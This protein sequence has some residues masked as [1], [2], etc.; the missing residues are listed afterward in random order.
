MREAPRTVRAWS[1][2]TAVTW[3][4]GLGGWLSLWRTPIWSTDDLVFAIRAGHPGGA[5][6]GAELWHF[7]QVDVWERNGRTADAWGQAIFST[8]WAIGPLMALLCLAQSFLWWRLLWVCLRPAIPAR[9]AP[10]AAWGCAVA[11]LAAPFALHHLVARLAGTVFFFMSATVGYLGGMVLLGGSLLSALQL[12]RRATTARSWG[13][14]AVVLLLSGA[15]GA[16]HN[17]VIALQLIA[18][19][20]LLSS[21]LWRRRAAWGPRATVWV[22]LALSA[23]RFAAPGLWARTRKVKAPLPLEE[24]GFLTRRA[25]LAAMSLLSQLETAGR[26]YLGIALAVVA[27]G[28]WVGWHW[29]R[30]RALVGA[31]V[32]GLGGGGALAGWLVPRLVAARTAANWERSALADLF[33]SRS[34]LLLVLALL[35]AGGCAVALAGLAAWQL[36]SLEVGVVLTAAVAAYAVPV[37]L[38]TTGPRPFYFGIAL[39]YLLALALAGLT[40]AAPARGRLTAPDG[41]PRIAAAAPAWR[42]RG[43]RVVSGAAAAASLALLLGPAG[44]GAGQL[45]RDWGG[46]MAAWRQVEDQLRAAQAGQVTEVVIPRQLP[47]MHLLGD[48]LTVSEGSPQRLHFLYDLDQSVTVTF[49]K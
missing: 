36:G 24:A 10:A 3:L 41:A 47:H 28:L 18:V 5:V 27:L 13:P 9:L 49:S 23:A 2:A 38:G 43:G 48:Y 1:V 39:A 29:A 31:L 8:G 15:L 26:L 34:A 21:V 12:V 11:C 33:T 7:A 30:G 25:A 32:A 6:R 37:A 35:V 17:E 42:T 40:V 16:M 44:P 20:V 19:A 22:L 14:P 4:A 45:W 46:N